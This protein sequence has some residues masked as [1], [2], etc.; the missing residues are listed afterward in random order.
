MGGS[1]GFR[2]AAW[3]RAAARAG[4]LAEERAGLSPGHVSED[5][6]ASRRCADGCRGG[7]D[8]PLWGTIQD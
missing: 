4:Q 7:W 6:S 1:G 8:A 3:V 2:P 5:M